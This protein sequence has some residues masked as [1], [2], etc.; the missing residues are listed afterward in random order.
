MMMMVKGETK[1]RI[2][3]PKTER[4]KEVEQQQQQ[5]NEKNQFYI[6]NLQ[7]HFFMLDFLFLCLSA[8]DFCVSISGCW[9]VF[10]SEIHFYY[11]V[12]I[13]LKFC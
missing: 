9:L 11:L 12:S 4:K 6:F 10:F 2:N 5:Q 1:K 7:S 13:L 3:I 8:Y